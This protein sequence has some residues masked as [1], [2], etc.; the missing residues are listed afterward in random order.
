M[1]GKQNYQPELF[2]YLDLDKLITKRHLLRRIDRVLDLGFV[3]ELTKGYYSQ[4]KGRPS[5]DP[6]VYFRIQLIGYIYGIE[7]DRQLCE[8]IQV[9]ISYR[10]FAH[11]SFQD[12]VPDHSSLTRIRD[13]FGEKCFE[14][15]FKKIVEQ[16]KKA[17]LVPGKRAIVDA[18]LVEAD[19]SMKSL[20]LREENKDKAVKEGRVYSNETHTS[21]TDPDAKIV[22]RGKESKRLCH[23][24]HYTADAEARVIT[25]VR[26]TAGNVQDHLE[27]EKQISYAM[28]TFGLDIKEAVADK[29]Y[30]IG[31]CYEYLDKKKIRSYIPVKTDRHLA[32]REAGFK[33]NRRKNAYVCPKKEFLTARGHDIERK[34]TPYKSSSTVCKSC[35]VKESCTTSKVSGS[36]ARV[37]WRSD[38]ENLF[39]KVR[40]RMRTPNF[41]K[42]LTERKWKIEGLFGEAKE[43]H[44]L[45]VS[46]YRGRSKVQIQAYLT[47]TVQNLKRLAKDSIE[48]VES[49]I[50]MLKTKD[51][52]VSIC[53]FSTARA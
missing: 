7:S 37:L 16:C 49:I 26:V 4:E 13:R 38:Y 51:F 23:K 17:G 20:V 36:E 41:L 15:V 30:G 22:A 31:S 33:F 28:T 47:A 11:L 48:L 42:V 24:V 40:T 12:E 27:L 8:E 25:A 10:W 34:R 3:R 46:R 32:Q 45:R 21:S 39:E 9:N 1:Q 52:R 5:I 19:A 35:T 18:T 2:S 14:E 29:G 44:G 50:R 53:Y 43:R 6:E